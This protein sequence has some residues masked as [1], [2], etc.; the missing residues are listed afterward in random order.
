MQLALV[1]GPVGGFQEFSGAK[2][3]TLSDYGRRLGLSPAFHRT[4][5]VRQTRWFGTAIEL[6]FA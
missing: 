2:S 4:P 5:L 3:L 1:L 6:L